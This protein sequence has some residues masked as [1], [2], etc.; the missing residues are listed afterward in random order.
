MDQTWQEIWKII[1]PVVGTL[2]SLLIGLA[3]VYV[4]KLTERIQDEKLKQMLGEWVKAA[5]Q[6]Y[7]P[8]TGDAKFKF[9]LSL[10]QKY[11]LGKVDIEAAVADLRMGKL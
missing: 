6:I 9:V 1:A 4:K 10:A 11:G 5:E 8:A 3:C 7:G 2:L